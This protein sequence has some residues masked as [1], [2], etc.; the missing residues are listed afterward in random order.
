[1]SFQS[2]RPITDFIA[3]VFVDS[4]MIRDDVTV[5]VISKVQYLK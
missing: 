3:F 2:N 5:E 4:I 1:M